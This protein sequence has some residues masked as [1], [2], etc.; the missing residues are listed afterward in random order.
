MLASV[1]KTDPIASAMPVNTSTIPPSMLPSSSSGGPITSVT[2]PNTSANAPPTLAKTDNTFVV[3][4]T[5]SC[6]KS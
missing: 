2:N 5:A 4:P 6:T 3:G 1:L